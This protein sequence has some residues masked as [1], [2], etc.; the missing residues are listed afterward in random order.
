MAKSE[1]LS[2][3]ML[4]CI[5][6]ISFHFI[7]LSLLL[8][9]LVEGGGGRKRYNMIYGLPWISTF[10]SGDWAMII[11]TE[12][13]HEGQKR[14]I[15][16]NPYDILFLTRYFCPTPAFTTAKTIIGCSFRHFYQG[17][18]FLTWHCDVTTVQSV[19]SLERE[20]LALW[21]HIRRLF[22]HA[23]IGANAIFTSE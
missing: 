6:F 23:Q 5:F 9:F 1:T 14:S 13:L 19:K 18:S 17:P 16:C 10:Y 3:K 4:S 21:R 12:S 8:L 11:V 20:V 7:L 2:S 22:L 15:H